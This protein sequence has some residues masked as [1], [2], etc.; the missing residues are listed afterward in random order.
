MDPLLTFYLAG[1][2]IALVLFLI[3]LPTILEKPKT[4]KKRKLAK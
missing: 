2:F 3:A 1:G 4:K